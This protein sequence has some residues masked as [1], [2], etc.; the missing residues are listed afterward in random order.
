MPAQEDLA[1]LRIDRG[2]RKTYRAR[3]MRGFGWV[4]LLAA[5]GVG[6]WFGSASWRAPVV[7]LGS[8]QKASSLLPAANGQGEKRGWTELNA[9]GYIVAD[10]QSTVAAKYN[11]RVARLHVREA[12]RVKE[13]EVLAE[14][15]H[16]ELDA[17]IDQAQAEADQAAAQARR[18]EADAAHMASQV[19]QARQARVQAEAERGAAVAPQATLDAQIGEMRVM[20][21][22]A[23]RRLDLAVELVAK[24]AAEATLIEDRKTEVAAAEARLLAAEHRR[25]EADRQV[26]V[27]QA[28]ADWARLAVTTAEAQHAAAMAASEAS[29]AAHRAVAARVKVLEAQREDFLI[30]APFDGV[31]SERI[32]EEGE[33]VAPVSIGGTQAKGAIV[34]VVDWSSLQAEVDVAEA[35][36]ERVKAGGRAAIHVD[37]IPGRVYPGRIQRILPRADRSKATVQVRVEFLE[38]DGAFLPDMG[39]RVKF[40][41]EDAPVG[42]ERGLVVDPLVVP[43]AAVHEDGGKHFVWTVSG[44]SARRAAIEIGARRGEWFEVRSGL[45]L[46]DRVIVSGLDA[47]SPEGRPVR[48]HGEE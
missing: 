41:P 25:T 27:S 28:R 36:L 15:D 21:A 11:A 18:A 47:R 12:Q 5:A 4:V 40:F 6:G 42:A 37:A 33:I 45:E 39:V 9:A 35:Y 8:V 34:T 17:M 14:L 19:E 23:R 2:P 29:R 31:I 30:R 13:N 16:R 48:V 24:R 10:R 3:R 46:G 38:P 44:G 32:A 26:T 7:A 22:D 1:A 43:A 20:A